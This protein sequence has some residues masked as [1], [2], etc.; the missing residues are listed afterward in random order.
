MRHAS[1]GTRS[2][3]VANAALILVIALAVAAV[4]LLALRA[5]DASRELQLVAIALVFGGALIVLIQRFARP[6]TSRWEPSPR[7]SP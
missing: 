2:R 3:R 4:V 5:L 6:T 1:G 7:P